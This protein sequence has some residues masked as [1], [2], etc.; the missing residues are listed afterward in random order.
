MKEE[1]SIFSTKSLKHFSVF[2]NCGTKRLRGGSGL[3][4]LENTFS[5]WPWCARHN[6]IEV[7]LVKAFYQN[8]IWF[9][10]LLNY[11]LSIYTDPKMPQDFAWSFFEPQ[12][13]TPSYQYLESVFLMFRLETHPPSP[14]K[15]LSFKSET[16]RYV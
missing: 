7:G 1:T 8:L 6:I 5:R 4:I 2:F 10:Y 11:Y 16:N 9:L 12:N 14:L 3:N 15:Q 13:W